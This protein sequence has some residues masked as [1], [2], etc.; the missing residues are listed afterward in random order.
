M[1]K[2]HVMVSEKVHLTK[3][4]ETMLITLYGRA[5]Q[6]RSKHPILRDTW[7]EEAVQRVDYD[8][9]KLKVG[10]RAALLFACRAT[11][12]DLW[13]RSFLASHPD[14]TV[15][16]LGCGLDSRFY[17]IAPPPSVRWFDL[18]YPEVIALRQHL[19]SEHPGY[20]MLG[21]SLAA[22]SWLDEV[23]ADRPAMI[24][25]EGVTMY[26]TEQIM[27]ALL[28]ALTDHF[29]SG[30]LAFD[31]HTP[32]LVRWLMKTG[33]TVRGTGATFGWGIDN[34]TDIKRLEPRLE[35]IT[36]L[37][38]HDLAAYATMP[39]SMRALVRAMDIIPALR[40]MR[41]LLYSFKRS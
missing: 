7:A 3:E 14:A 18:D 23:P 25:A 33:A 34:P 40:V 29:A 41:C 28:N 37:K 15:L 32:Q 26:L 31:A 38:A 5:L 30:Q 22:L 6:S 13:T 9:A 35:L 11:Q 8:F 21:S 4:K 24:V 2:D 12:L 20:H 36:E 1:Q 19:Y 17:R 27:Q 39:W 16:H 10:Q